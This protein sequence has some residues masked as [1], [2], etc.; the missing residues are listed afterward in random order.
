MEP[1]LL[2]TV[3][4]I[5]S[6]VWGPL[7]IQC[8]LNDWYDEP[9]QVFMSSYLWTMFIALWR[10]PSCTT[11]PEWYMPLTPPPRPNWAGE[12]MEVTIAVMS[13]EHLNS[14]F[15]LTMKKTSKLHITDSIW[16]ESTGD[17]MKVQWC[18]KLF[19]VMTSWLTHWGRDKMAAIFR[20]TFSNAFSWMKMLEFRLWNHW[21]LFLRF[22]LTI[23]QHW[24]R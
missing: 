1:H 22:E 5:Y 8:P 12:H 23:S 9:W 13:H 18:G 6:G 3:Q 17:L 19:H 15:R 14:M 11:R 16:V 2:C 10:S 4:L 24:F 20:T 21:N 7:S